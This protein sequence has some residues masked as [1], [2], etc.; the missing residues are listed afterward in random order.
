MLESCARK[1][2]RSCV[3]QAVQQDI[4][5]M[6]IPPSQG[7]P[8]AIA[9]II[10]S[11]ATTPP[12]VDLSEEDQDPFCF[13]SPQISESSIQEAFVVTP[14]TL[15]SSTSRILMPEDLDTPPARCLFPSSSLSRKHHVNASTPPPHGNSAGTTPSKRQRRIAPLVSPLPEDRT[16][17]K[18]CYYEVRGDGPRLPMLVEA[19]HFVMHSP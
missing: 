15:F 19:A 6:Q 3:E 13:Q 7:I 18:N 1:V 11:G 4:P 8:K 17:G 10:P 5:P 9:T 14:M 12:K 16:N 2:I